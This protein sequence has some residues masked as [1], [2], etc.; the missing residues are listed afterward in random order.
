MWR[1]PDRARHGFQEKAGNFLGAEDF[2][3]THEDYSALLA[4][5]I[6]PVIGNI[7]IVDLRR[8]NVAKL[9]S[10]L[11][12]TPYQANRSLALVSSIW[13]W[14]AKRDVVAFADNPAKCEAAPR[15]GPAQSNFV[16]ALA[17]RSALGPHADLHPGWSL[18]A[19]AR[20]ECANYLKN[21][22]YV[23]V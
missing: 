17:R 7:R 6:L 14:A 3:R 23:S 9:H 16:R 4:R 19:F 1:P 8:A 18:D 20:D 11:S 5:H 22:R 10:K 12:E 21:S 15:V 2:R 13:N